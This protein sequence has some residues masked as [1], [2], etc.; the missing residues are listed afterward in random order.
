MMK[1][2]TRKTVRDTE[3]GDA[4]FRPVI[5]DRTEEATLGSLPRNGELAS[6]KWGKVSAIQ[7]SWLQAIL[8]NTTAVIYSKNLEGRY[9]YVNTAFESLF[10]LDRTQVVGKTD[11]DLFPTPTANK[12][13]I[14]DLRV[15]DQCKPTEFEEKVP[16]INACSVPKPHF[17][18][19]KLLLHNTLKTRKKTAVLF[20]RRMT[21]IQVDAGELRTTYEDKPRTP[22]RA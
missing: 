8:D 5:L 11:C 17:C 10:Q 3:K 16:S 19:R 6:R 12:F 20:F 13:R 9:L 22:L 2:V 4:E 21:P 1:T 18:I 14:N 15:L 7:D